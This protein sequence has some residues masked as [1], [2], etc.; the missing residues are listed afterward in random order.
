MSTLKELA[1]A[2]AATR[3]LAEAA[4]ALAEEQRQILA[5]ELKAVG[6]DSV[7]AEWDG[8]AV[9]KSSFVQ[10]ETKSNI[11][12]MGVAAYT[13]YIT[14]NYPTET[15]LTVNPAFTK[16]LLADAIPDPETGVVVDAKTGEIIPG[17]LAQDTVRTPYL[18]T[19]FKPAGADRL[20][21]AMRRRQIALPGGL[22]ALGS[23]DQV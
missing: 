6:G 15:I 21:E 11:S 18:R 10:P 4:T 17:L 22:A 3:A 7:T 2:Y 12:V 9:A 23:G 1:L 16:A 8:H 20:L 5:D 13:D 14:E 19:A